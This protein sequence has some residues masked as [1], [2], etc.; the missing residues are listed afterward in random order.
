MY[1]YWAYV[2]SA[3]ILS[4][5]LTSITSNDEHVITKI[6]LY[7]LKDSAYTNHHCITKEYFQNKDELCGSPLKDPSKRI[8][9]KIA[10]HQASPLPALLS[11]QVHL[12]VQTFL[13]KNKMNSTFIFFS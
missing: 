8:S 1:I 4:V 3:S 10:N 13:K 12:D 2:Q 7:L 11:P 9:P 6:N 5:Y